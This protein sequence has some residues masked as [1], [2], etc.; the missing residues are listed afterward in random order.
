MATRTATQRRASD[1]N[2]REITDLILGYLN[3]NLALKTRRAF[4][5]HLGLCPDCVAFL[6]TYKKTVF[7]SRALRYDDVPG[8]LRKQVRSFLRGKVRTS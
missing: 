1:K 4:E 6:E 7:F 3:G 8:E 5:K 2:C